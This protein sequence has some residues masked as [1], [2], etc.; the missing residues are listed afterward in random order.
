MKQADAPPDAVQ[1][2]EGSPATPQPAQ[3]LAAEATSRRFGQLSDPGSANVAC[4]LQTKTT[5]V[6]QL[7]IHDSLSKRTRMYQI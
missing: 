3:K 2:A 6:Y 7:L 5:V 4:G 1:E